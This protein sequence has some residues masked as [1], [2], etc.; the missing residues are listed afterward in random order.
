MIELSQ[1]HFHSIGQVSANKEFGKVEIKVFPIEYRFNNEEIVVDKVNVIDLA[2]KSNEGDDNIQVILTNSI[3]AKWFN[4][5]GN[6]WTAP[7]VRRN[8]KVL[9]WRLGTSEQY[10]WMDFNDR[11]VKRLE[12]VVYVWSADPKNPIAGDLS[13]AYYIEI[14]THNKTI[15]L[16]TS[17]A[18]EEPYGYT[19][20]FNTG[21]G[22]FVL[23]DTDANEVLLDSANTLIRMTN[24]AKSTFELNKDVINGFAPKDVNLTAGKQ[25]NLKCVDFTLDATNSITTTTKTHNGNATAS[26][27]MD[28]PIGT[29]TTDVHIKNKLG[30]ATS[31]DTPLANVGSLKVGSIGAVG[32]I[33]MPSGGGG[34]SAPAAMSAGGSVNCTSPINFQKPIT[35]IDLTFDKGAI[36]VLSGTSAAF[37]TGSFPDG[38]GPH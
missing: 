22:H 35:G 8:D 28:T 25:M 34:G 21:E 19:M 29:F 20:Q 3:T 38:H 13:N 37:K 7:D 32:G 36:K 17:Q 1:L 15:T 2:F 4:L 11:N 27:T 31:I 5:N 18:N 12:T 16:K 33:V 23:Q 30:V 10:Y 9:I 24:A 6:R 14:S 26:Y